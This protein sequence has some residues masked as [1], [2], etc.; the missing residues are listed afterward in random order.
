MRLLASVGLL[1]A[2]ACVGQQ[3]A[4]EI[5]A[6]TKVALAATSPVWA[7]TVKL[8]DS[9]YAE[10]AFPVTVNDQMAIPPRTYVRGQIDILTLPQKLSGHAELRVQFTQMV[11]ADGSAVALADVAL[12]T[13]N[14][15]VSPRS[16]ILLDNGTQFEMVLERPLTLDGEKVAAA[17]R[18][19]KP[20]KATPSK[21]ATRCRP[22]PATQ[23][24]EGTVIPGTP[25]TVI[26]GTPD[27][28]I[29]GVDGAPPTVIPGTPSTTMGGTDPTV[30]GATPVTS[31]I[32][33]PGPPVVV[34]LPVA[35]KESFTASGSVLVAGQQLTRGTYEATWD[36]L[37]PV[38]EVQIL[39]KGKPVATLQARVVALGK[40][41][42]ATAYKPR[43]NADGSF[44]L[45][46]IQFKG[47]TY[48]LRFDQ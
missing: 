36:G 22:I 39:R 26:P 23:G 21:S 37:G 20:V 7:K 4:I 15:V 31:E 33:C 46:S 17:V 47:R 42:P 30:I 29:P 38:A 6:G 13:L 24:S 45:R 34:N 25:P 12:A 44:S 40:T 35:H 18:M 11:F 19:T 9:V 48:G 32:P 8:G 5:P 3:P 27:T 43:K 14:V 16:D 28:V 41:A 1:S 2:M 10:T